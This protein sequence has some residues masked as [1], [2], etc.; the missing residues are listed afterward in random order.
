M[1]LKN[2]NAIFCIF[3]L[4]LGVLLT[5]CS[6]QKVAEAWESDA[7]GFQCDQCSLKFYTDKDI[8]ASKCPG[9]SNGTPFSA[10]GYVCDKDKHTTIFRKGRAA[11]CEQCKGSVSAMKKP[12]AAELQ[13]WGAVKKS[14]NEV[15]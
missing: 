2:S 3:F 4:A 13:A 5:G 8:F 12:S 6:E 11:I 15:N 1:T 14:Q 7:N 10:V 9:C